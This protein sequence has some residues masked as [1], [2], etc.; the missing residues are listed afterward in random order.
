MKKVVLFWVFLVLFSGFVY[1]LPNDE[2][3][4]QAANTL[5][6]PFADL[7]SFVQSHQPQNT[8]ADAITITS[9]DLMSAYKANQIRADSQYKNKTLKITG[10]V[11]EVG[12]Y[13]TGIHYVRLDGGDRY[14]WVVVWIKSSEA[15]RAASLNKDQTVTLIGI[16]NGYASETV[17]IKDATFAR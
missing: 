16:C 2:Q 12:Q 1:S 4:R 6:V 17:T 13:S 14:D 10:G 8:S 7:K 9:K 15:T 5:G 3:I 11:Q